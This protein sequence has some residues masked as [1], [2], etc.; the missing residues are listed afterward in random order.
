MPLLAAPMAFPRPL[1]LFLSEF[2]RGTLTVRRQELRG[3][4]ERM[5]YGPART[6]TRLGGVHEGADE[7]ILSSAPLISPDGTRLAFGLGLGQ[8]VTDDPKLGGHP[9][10][11]THV[12]V[13]IDARTGRRLS[14]AEFEGP[15]G[16][17]WNGS[18]NELGILATSRDRRRSSVYVLGMGQRQRLIRRDAARFFWAGDTLLTATWSRAGKTVLWED[19]L[20][21]ARRDWRGYVPAI[22]RQVRGQGVKIDQAAADRAVGMPGIGKLAW[23]PESGRFEDEMPRVNARERS[24]VLPGRLAAISV[25]R[26]PVRTPDGEE[27]VG[28]VSSITRKVDVVFFGNRRYHVSNEGFSFSD[29]TR[30]VERRWNVGRGF[31]AY[32][33]TYGP[34]GAE[35]GDSGFG[36]VDVRS[37]R[38]RYWPDL[39]VRERLYDIQWGL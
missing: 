2:R 28:K 14:R 7:G 29:S 3:S 11:K 25:N 1:A 17:A 15:T 6:L 36:V 20:P 10:T 35:E 31:V 16:Y 33:S 39:E 22:R 12:V 19:L 23:L 9:I 13:V 27:L 37:G 32:F 8:I 4:G 18:S 21:T 34:P 24:V 5:I 38:K 30:G 26:D